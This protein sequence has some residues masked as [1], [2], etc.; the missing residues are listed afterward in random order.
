MGL[1]GFKKKR[2]L[3]PLEMPPKPGM[4]PL[5]EPPKPSHD[6]SFEI[7]HA[8]ELGQPVPEQNDFKIPE[9]KED[10]QEKTP[11]LSIPKQEKPV[12]DHAIPMPPLEHE[13]KPEPVFDYDL[14]QEETYKGSPLPVE[15]LFIEGEDF[16]EI[17]NGINRV[18]NLVSESE[19]IVATL[20]ELKKAKQ[21]ELDRFRKDLED[22]QRKI[23]FV[24]KVLAEE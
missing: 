17:L 22:V 4:D 16:K 13:T 1:F 21:V 15:P 12:E 5:P 10:S 3:P 24:D 14:P 18:K 2:P 20:E 19:S 11:D 23:T 7:P 8:P 6:T 9:M